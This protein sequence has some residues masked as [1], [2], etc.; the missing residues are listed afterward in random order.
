MPRYIIA[1]GWQN[2]VDEIERPTLQARNRA[3]ATGVD[4]GDI[5]DSV[6]WAIPYD[7]DKARE[8]GLRVID[9][10]DQRVQAWRSQAPWR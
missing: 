7:E 1:F 9:E 6:A 4:L 3:I 8:L 10:R 5:D 2:D